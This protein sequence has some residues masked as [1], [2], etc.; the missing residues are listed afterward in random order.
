MNLFRTILNLWPPFRSKPVAGF[1]LATHFHVLEGPSAERYALEGPSAERYALEGPS[2]ERYAL[3]G[4]D[5]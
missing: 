3:E 2:A 5:S 1:Q 4:S